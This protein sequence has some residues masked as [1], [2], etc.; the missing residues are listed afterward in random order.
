MKGFLYPILLTLPAFA[1]PQ[2]G[3]F[4]AKAK[5]PVVPLQELKWQAPK[6]AA[7][8]ILIPLAGGQQ[9][10]IAPAPENKNDDEPETRV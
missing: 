8:P 3:P 1:L 6:D 9:L 10:E 2:N 7:Q 5:P 4:E